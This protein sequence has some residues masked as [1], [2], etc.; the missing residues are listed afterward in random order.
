DAQD[1]KDLITDRI[2]SGKVAPAPFNNEADIAKN[3][4]DLKDCMTPENNKLVQD[5]AMAVWK[6]NRGAL[7]AAHDAHIVSDADYQTY[8]NRGIEYT[9]LS[10]IMDTIEGATANNHNAKVN[11]LYL[12][13]QSII[14]ELEGSERTNKNPIIASYEAMDRIFSQIARNKIINELL[15]SAEKD[16]S[17]VGTLF[18]KVPDSY[19]PGVNEYV[20]GAY[21][22]DGEQVRYAVPRDLGVA[23]EGAS[24]SAINLGLK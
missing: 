17:G 13:S 5:A 9:P 10:R 8:V 22:G 14:R 19:K 1:S 12:K 11:P 16:P 20:V 24:P 2:N 4:R 21:R 15:D 18:K 6:A 3:L 7:D 23:L